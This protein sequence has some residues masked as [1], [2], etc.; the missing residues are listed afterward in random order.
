MRKLLSY[1]L[2]A[3]LSLALGACQESSTAP[4]ARAGEVASGALSGSQS[5]ESACVQIAGSTD[6]VR[7]P[8]NP[9]SVEGTIRGS[10]TGNFRYES[11]TEIRARHGPTIHTIAE[12]TITLEEAGSLGLEPGDE[13][14]TSSPKLMA[15]LSSARYLKVTDVEGPGVTGRFTE[16]GELKNLGDNDPSQPATFFNDRAVGHYEGRLCPTE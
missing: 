6:G 4:E 3:L 16:K 2:V 10:L 12:G 14:Q 5:P 13:L 15:L 7:T 11:S 9:R 8:P 1:A